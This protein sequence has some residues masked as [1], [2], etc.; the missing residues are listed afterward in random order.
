M[1]GPSPAS[2]A[3]WEPRRGRPRRWRGSPGLQSQPRVHP[4]RSP[5][6]LRQPS[7]MCPFSA[8]GLPPVSAACRGPRLGP[9][10]GSLGLRSPLSGRGGRACCWGGG[11]GHLG[12]LR[13]LGRRPGVSRGRSGLSSRRPDRHRPLRQPP[14]LA[15]RGGFPPR[16][17]QEDGG[18]GAGLAVVAVDPLGGAIGV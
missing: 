7:G 14:L 12:Q 5:L 9:R 13:L 15:L 4:H 16:P 8:P 6:R 11:G 1:R 3:C 18:A 10:R 2:V 17:F